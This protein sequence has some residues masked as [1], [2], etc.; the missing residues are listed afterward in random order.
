MLKTAPAPREQDNAKAVDPDTVLKARAARRPAQA[1]TSSAKKSTSTAR[2]VAD[3]EAKAKARDQMVPSRVQP[4]S[5]MANPKTLSKEQ[6]GED[7]EAKASARKQMVSSSSVRRSG[8]GGGG[9]EQL[10]ATEP[11]NRLSCIPTSYR[12]RGG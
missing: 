3:N 9:D 1:S 2:S 8:G 11:A 7:K 12:N 4:E 6:D 5:G 10:S